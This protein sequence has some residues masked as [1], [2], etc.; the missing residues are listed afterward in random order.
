MTGCFLRNHLWKILNT[1]FHC[2]LYFFIYLSLPVSL[3]LTLTSAHTFLVFPMSRNSNSA[4]SFCLWP[5]VHIHPSPSSAL[6]EFIFVFQSLT[7]DLFRF[8][9][10]HYPSLCLPSFPACL[11]LPYSRRLPP[12]NQPFPFWNPSC[13]SFGL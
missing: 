4:I 12:V 3:L 8:S 6:H 11:S 9:Y 5:P 13:Q 10:L 1:E 2:P 7:F